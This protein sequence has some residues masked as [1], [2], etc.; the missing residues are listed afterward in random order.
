MNPLPQLGEAV[1]STSTLAPCGHR[2]ALRLAR[3]RVGQ[4]RLS[5]S[6][7]HAANAMPRR[8]AIRRA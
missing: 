5:D 6:V 7:Q 8:I 3:F 1:V 2:L 4:P